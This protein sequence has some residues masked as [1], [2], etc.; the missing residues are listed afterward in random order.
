[1]SNNIIYCPGMH[2]PKEPTGPT[3]NGIP[4]KPSIPKPVP[5]KMLP[6]GVYD[7]VIRS[8]SVDVQND[9]VQSGDTVVTIFFELDLHTG[10]SIVRVKKIYNLTTDVAR[11]VLRGELEVLGY[12]VHDRHDFKRIQPQLVGQSVF[13]RV[14]TRSGT[15]I[16]PN[17]PHFDRMYTFVTKKQADLENK[18]NSRINW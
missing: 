3:V 6:D 10:T 18:I 9:T 16:D 7:G 5:S 12:T 15:P 8:V 4:E 14:K 1:M 17:E 11:N 2:S 13:V